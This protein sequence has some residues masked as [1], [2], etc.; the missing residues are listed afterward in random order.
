MGCLDMQA[1]VSEIS[2]NRL[3]KASFL[4]ALLVV[5]LHVGIG[6]KWVGKAVALTGIA[7]PFFFVA[8]GYLFAGRIGEPGWY[9]RQ[10]KSRVRSLF[11]PYVVWNAA[12]WCFVIGLTTVLG[13]LGVKYGGLETIDSLMWQRWDILGVNPV[14]FPALGLLWFVRCLIVITFVS[15]V[16]LLVTRKWGGLFVLLGCVGLVWFSATHPEAEQ[17]WVRVWLAKGWIRAAV[18]FGLGVWIRFNGGEDM[19]VSRPLAAAAL[20]VGWALLACGNVVVSSL[21][22]PVA[23]WGLWYSLSGAAWPRWLTSCSF[24]I[25]VLHAFWGTIT[26]GLISAAGLK[27]WTTDSAFAWLIK[28]GIMVAGPLV[29]VWMM[30]RFMPRVG[31]VVFGGR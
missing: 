9:M 5:A 8:A 24:P 15:P 10:V 1:K 30:R 13:S 19:R 16:F 29:T 12:Y 3:G 23:M 11:V 21:A 7:V 27:T 31:G 6:P 18:Y 14:G 20:V 22:I 2:S 4:S 25:Y 17:G 28:W 26:A